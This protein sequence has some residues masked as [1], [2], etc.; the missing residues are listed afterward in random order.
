MNDQPNDQQLQ[1]DVQQALATSFLQRVPDIAAALVRE[2]M[3]EVMAV[4]EAISIAY[5][6][7]QALVWMVLAPTSAQRADADLVRER[8]CARVYRTL[9]QS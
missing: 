8:M 1:H 9:R 4:H 3:N 6:H 5:E 7:E 2:G